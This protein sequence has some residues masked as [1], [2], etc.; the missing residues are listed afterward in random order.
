MQ[1]FGLGLT[2][3]AVMAS[4]LAFA[5]SAAPQR[6]APTDAPGGTVTAS[7]D[8]G[9]EFP[10]MKGYV[11]TQTLT[12]VAPGSGRAWHSHAGMPEIV[13]ILSGTLTD[14]RN[15]GSPVAYGPGSTLINAGGTQ[16]TWANLGKEPVVFVATAIRMPK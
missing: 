9:A 13:R 12:T 2:C 8:L 15:G 3:F 11:F 1:R 14:A 5:Q 7:V 16:H 4:S 6:L 10:Q